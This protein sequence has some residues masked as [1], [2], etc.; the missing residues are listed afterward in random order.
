MVNNEKVQVRGKRQYATSESLGSLM[1]Y[2]TSPDGRGLTHTMSGCGKHIPFTKAAPRP[3]RRST[4]A[5]RCRL[6]FLSK[7]AIKL[8]PILPV[9]TCSFSPVVL[10]QRPSIGHESL[11]REISFRYISQHVSQASSPFSASVKQP[12]STRIHQIC[13]PTPTAEPTGKD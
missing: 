8:L 6:S 11:Y 5:P 9:Q 12:S 4:R 1:Y 3:L 10:R 13:R 7:A 2:T